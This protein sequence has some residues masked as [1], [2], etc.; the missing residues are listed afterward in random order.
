MILDHKSASTLSNYDVCSGNVTTRHKNVTCTVYFVFNHTTINLI[1][2]KITATS[3]RIHENK[4][5]A[6]SSRIQENATSKKVR[7]NSPK[8]G[9]KIRDQ[10]HLI[11][12]ES[13]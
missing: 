5:T 6:T 9:S 2:K 12:K 1:K 10:S 8:L 4:I 13:I 3:S 11:P 7:L